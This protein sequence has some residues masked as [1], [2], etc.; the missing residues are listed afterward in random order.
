MVTFSPLVADH[1]GPAAKGRLPSNEL[2]KQCQ[3]LNAQWL[4][5]Q[6]AFAVPVYVEGD[7]SE[8]WRISVIDVTN[9]TLIRCLQPEQVHGHVLYMA[10]CGIKEA[11]D[12]GEFDGRKA[13]VVN[14]CDAIAK[15]A[16]TKNP[17]S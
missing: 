14:I 16:N 12:R 11:Y 9:Q 3:E 5:S 13:T 7:L 1:V 6:D 4:S 10:V 8:G 2:V 15:M 17:Y